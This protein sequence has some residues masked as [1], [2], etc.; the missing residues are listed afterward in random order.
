MLLITPNVRQVNLIVGVYFK[1]GAAFVEFADKADDLITWLRSKTFVL[2]LLRE[3]QEQSG[4]TA[5]T[6][7]RPVLT[8][9]TAHYCAYDRLLTLRP[10]LLIL[11]KMDKQH[12]DSQII[13]GKRAA[14]DKASK[15][16][17]LIESGQ[18]WHA[19]ARY[20]Y[21]LILI[22]IRVLSIIII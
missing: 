12:L 22:N 5:L 20:V 10:F 4:K 1:S 9:W 18:F 3:T 19:L 14:R 15:M 8:H 7:I 13:T 17:D 6:V 2:A 11:I 16:V 21:T